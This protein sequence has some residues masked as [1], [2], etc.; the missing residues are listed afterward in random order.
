M[1]KKNLKENHK[2]HKLSLEKIITYLTCHSKRVQ[3]NIDGITSQFSCQIIV[4]K[5]ELRKVVHGVE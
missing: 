1:I 3:K 5:F 4:L 2:F